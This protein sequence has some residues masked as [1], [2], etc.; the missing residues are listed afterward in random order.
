MKSQGYGKWS[1][2]PSSCT[3][4]LSR[5]SAV[6]WPRSCFRCRVCPSLGQGREGAALTLRSWWIINGSL[7]MHCVLPGWPRCTWLEPSCSSRMSHVLSCFAM[8][9]LTLLLRRVTKMYPRCFP[10]K[11][12]DD[13]S[14]ILEA[15]KQGKRKRS[16]R[17]HS[18]G[19]GA[20]AGD[21]QRL[22]ISQS[23]KAFAISQLSWASIA[24]VA[25][26]HF[27]S[28][29]WVSSQIPRIWGTLNWWPPMKS[30]V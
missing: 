7:S 14:P 25:A 22:F 21:C 20:K 4:C 16:W 17:I 5:D 24:I 2:F 30:L 12:R 26:Q 9:L 29:P 15:G 27:R 10:T 19:D 18:S 11:R 13:L 8:E 3:L 28:D 1:N 6:G 23:A